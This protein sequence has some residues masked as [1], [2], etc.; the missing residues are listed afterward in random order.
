MQLSTFIHLPFLPF[1]HV[2]PLTFNP[3]QF[4]SLISSFSF[5]LFFNFIV[6]FLAIRCVNHYTFSV[7]FYVCRKRMFFTQS[8]YSIYMYI[9]CIYSPNTLY[10]HS[11]QIKN[12][13]QIIKLLITNLTD[14][15]LYTNSPKYF[16]NI[17]PH[18]LRFIVM[19]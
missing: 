14:R 13:N 4:Y 2:A 9:H 15:K 17:Y 7:F 6:S 10:N 8:Y 3:P 12:V 5:V 16:H 19:L 1:S 18:H 11:N